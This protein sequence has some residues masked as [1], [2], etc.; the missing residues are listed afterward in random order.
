MHDQ[1]RAIGAIA[2]DRVIRVT[3]RQPRDQP[4]AVIV[5]LARPVRGA[6]AGAGAVRPA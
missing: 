3:W 2:G 1:E 6:G 5:R 4:M